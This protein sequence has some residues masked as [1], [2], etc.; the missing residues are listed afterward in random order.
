MMEYFVSYKWTGKEKIPGVMGKRDIDG[1]GNI[2]ITI[3][4]G[5]YD[6]S[7]IQAICKVVVDSN[8]NVDEAVVLFYTKFDER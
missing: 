8:P 6:M 5:I 2:K 7:S 4:G 3:E 1:F